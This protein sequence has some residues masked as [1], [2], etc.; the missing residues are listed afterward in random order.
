MPF[1]VALPIG[2]LLGGAIATK[3]GDRAVTF[4][5]LLIAAFAYWRVHFWTADVRT[6]SYDLVG[7]HLPTFYADL[8][9]AGIGLGI[10]IGPITSATLRAVPAAQHGIAS[11]FVVVARMI[12]MLI[13]FASLTAFGLYRFNQNLATLPIEGT[14]LVERAA[15]IGNNVRTAYAAQYGDIFF[16]TMIVCVIGALLGL[17]I[18]GRNTHADEPDQ[19]TEVVDA[20]PS[21]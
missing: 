16:I 2:A 21:P 15:S 5:G 1:L 9:L 7:L 17:L 8:A 14:T 6:A 18:T 11:A 10:V 4:V 13:G 20:A 19:E 12:G 3:V